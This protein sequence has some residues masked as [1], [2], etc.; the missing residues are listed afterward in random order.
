VVE[1]LTMN[2]RKKK[3]DLCPTVVQ[4]IKKYVFVFD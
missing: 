2:W 1:L 4:Q 3:S